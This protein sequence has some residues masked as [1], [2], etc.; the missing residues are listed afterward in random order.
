[1]RPKKLPFLYGLPSGLLAGCLVLAAG[2]IATLLPNLTRA[3][4]K[5]GDIV[6]FSPADDRGASDAARIAVRR[7]GLPGCVLDLD[8]IRRTG[9][10]LVVE[11]RLTRPEPAF[12]LHW[13]GQRTSVAGD[14]CGNSADMIIEEADMTNLAFAA[15]GGSQQIP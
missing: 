2:I 5:V 15:G 9:G 8:A 6:V 3:A 14:D 7:L 4:P 12:R 10:S 11:A 13:A 1:M